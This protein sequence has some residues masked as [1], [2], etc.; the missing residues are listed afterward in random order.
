MK[1]YI[2]FH[3]RRQA[4]FPAQRAGGRVAQTD[5]NG[6]RLQVRRGLE[7]RVEVQHRARALQVVPRQLQLCAPR[8]AGGARRRAPEPLLEHAGMRRL[9]RGPRSPDM[10]CTFVTWNLT[11]G[12]AGVLATQM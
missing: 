6:P 3:H 5:P 12:P 1:R 7:R 8:F 4:H 11:V 9:G 2:R 10:V